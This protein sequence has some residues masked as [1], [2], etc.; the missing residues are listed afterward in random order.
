MVEQGE[1]DKLDHPVTELQREIDDK[2]QALYS[3]RVLEQARNPRNLG[4]MEAPDAHA[5][6]TGWCGDTMEIYLRLNGGMIQEA[7]FMTDGCDPAVASGNMLTTMVQG[8]AL[9]EANRIDPQDLLL[10][11]DS[12]PDESAHCAELAV[13][14]LREAI[15]NVQGTHATGAL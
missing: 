11:L 1:T 13:K 6:I 7:T 4:C 9:D 2:D 8:M 3:A 15:A 10:A 12:L 14:T 5:I